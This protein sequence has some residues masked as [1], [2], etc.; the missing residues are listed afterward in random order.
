M[1]I[2]INVAFKDNVVAIISGDKEHLATV[3][4]NKHCSELNVW[5]LRNIDLDSPHTVFLDD[6]G[7]QHAI[8]LASNREL[9]R[10]PRSGKYVCYRNAIFDTTLQKHLDLLWKCVTDDTKHMSKKDR[11][12]HLHQLS[13]SISCFGRFQEQMMPSLNDIRMQI[14]K[15]DAKLTEAE[16]YNKVEKKQIEHRVAQSHKVNTGDRSKQDQFNDMIVE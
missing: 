6:N 9:N 12:I 16:A 5:I 1:G 13:Q 3:G 2:A 4:P 14:V 11:Y 7:S 15:F 8:E 10:L